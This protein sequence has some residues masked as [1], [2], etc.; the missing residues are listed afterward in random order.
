MDRRAR[1]SRVRFPFEFTRCIRRIKYQNSISSGI[2]ILRDSPMVAPS[3]P[4]P[5]SSRP[6]CL[7]RL[8]SAA[9][10][11]R[12]ARGVHYINVNARTGA[13]PRDERRYM[14]RF[15][16]GKTTGCCVDMTRI[17]SRK[18]HSNVIADR[19]GSGGSSGL[20]ATMT[21]ISDPI[22][23]SPAREAVE[24]LLVNLLAKLCRFGSAFHFRDDE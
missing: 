19:A 4:H 8:S 24:R 11:H 3:T 15:L 7:H 21:S 1:I 5:P 13:S 18:I 12:R 10:L 16:S 17:F 22:R 23:T 9:F 14:W 2:A 6:Y 20:L